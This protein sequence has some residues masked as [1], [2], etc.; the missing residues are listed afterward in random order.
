MAVVAASDHVIDIGPGAGNEGGQ[1][2]T[3]GPPEKVARH[4]G[5]RTAPFLARQLGADGAAFAHE[6]ARVVARVP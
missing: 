1:V 2:V 6:R 3:A 5:S 4:R